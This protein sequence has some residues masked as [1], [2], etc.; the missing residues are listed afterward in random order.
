MTPIRLAVAG[1]TGR[2]G[3]AVVRL[4]A[5]DP[6]F[7][8]VAALTR[9]DDPRLG[10]DAG[11]AAG[12]DPVGVVVTAACATRC[13]VL[14]E[15]TVPAACRSWA[16]WCAAQ[17]VALV[18]GTTGL[19]DH[20]QAALRAAAEQVPVVWAPNMS[21]GV[22]LLLEL[23]EKISGCLSPA[24]DVEIC[25]THHRHKRDA[26]SG[27]AEALLA[28]VCAARGQRPDEVAVYGRRGECG[29]RPAGQIGVHAL[30][31]GENVG[32]HTVTFASADEA[33]T[34][35][36]QA[37]SRDAFAAGALRAARWLTGRAAGLYTMHDVLA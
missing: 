36:H 13:D 15:F 19:A 16:Q 26:P 37:F 18:S 33:L 10:E 31:L 24:W 12:V 35:R 2:T 20:D 4:A 30:R 17:G 5:A 14:I 11:R 32:E 25:E 23:V 21:V 29:P 27:T 3:A 22:N 7:E 6:A 9:P 1:C 34:L 8:L 28:A